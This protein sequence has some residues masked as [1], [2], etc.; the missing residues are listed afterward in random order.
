[1]EIT[2][3]I[4]IFLVFCFG[5]YLILRV[6]RNKR[7]AK[8]LWNSED[9]KD[10]KD[11]L[12]RIYSAD[13][14]ENLR[15]VFGE[16]VRCYPMYHDLFKIAMEERQQEI[17]QNTHNSSFEIK[18]KKIRRTWVLAFFINCFIEL[19]A[20]VTIFDIDPNIE[21]AFLKRITIISLTALLGII[22]W[23]IYHCA[24]KKKGTGLLTFIVFFSPLQMINSFAKEGIDLSPLFFLDLA[25]FGFYWFSTYR[26]RKVNYEVRARQ[27]L[28]GL[29]KNECL[30]ENSENM[31]SNPI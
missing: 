15:S 14:V 21:E 26:L 12:S 18:E 3:Y 24:Y 1:M 5:I 8:S 4:L 10:L 25:W 17:T 9:E 29:R 20:V 19:S 13:T 2:I 31:Q 23:V 30:T 7:K 27:Q 28:F 16:G 11:I 22:I 6:I